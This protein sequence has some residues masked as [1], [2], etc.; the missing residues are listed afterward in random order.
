M[1]QSM[2]TPA[3]AARGT[4]PDDVF[5]R[6]RAQVEERLHQFAKGPPTPAAAYTLEKEEVSQGK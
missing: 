6:L 5:A 4:V 1:A 2:A 3:P